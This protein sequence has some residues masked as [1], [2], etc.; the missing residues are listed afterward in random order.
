MC[1]PARAHVS[2]RQSGQR[3]GVRDSPPPGGR[4]RGGASRRAGCR[5]D[6]VT[7]GLTAGA[8]TPDSVV[9][10]V[11]ERLLAVRGYSAAH[12]PA[13]LAMGSADAMTTPRPTEVRLT[14]A[15][16]RRFEAID[17]N[18]RIA[19]RGGRRAAAAQARAVLL[20][21][22]DRRLSRAEPVGAAAPRRGSAR[23]SSSGSFHA[24][25]SAGR[26]VPP[27]SDGAADRADRRAEG[28]R[29]AQRRFAPHLHRRRPAQL[30]HLRTR[31]DAPVYFIDLDGAYKATRRT[32]TTAVVAYDQERVVLRTPV[33]IPVSKHPI[34]SVNLADPRIGLL[35]QVNELLAQ[36]RAR[37]R[38][39]RPGA[40]ADRAPRRP[41]GQRVRDAADAER[42]RRRAQEPAALREDQGAA[43]CSTIRARFPAR[44]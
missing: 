18:T 24:R 28:S 23:R 26:R 39:R 6:A 1:A 20:V 5:E 21:A 19:E 43:T 25:L 3:R 37:A 4:R 22:H 7:V 11:I 30:R 35:E 16:Q 14:L 2:H 27:R 32:R 29:A 38:P 15:P 33:I 36:T 41:D 44:R 42:S 34:D 13:P 9:G 12:L 10:D 40:R 31:P 8:S 17:V